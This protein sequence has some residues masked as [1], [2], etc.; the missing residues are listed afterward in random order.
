MEENDYLCRQTISN[1]MTDKYVLY[2]DE[3][4]DLNLS[5]F[6]PQFPIFTLCGIVVSEKQDK[7][8]NEKIDA[9]KLEI[10]NNT[11]IILHSR[12]I[13]KCQNGFEVLF[14]LEVKKKFLESINEIFG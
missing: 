11:N 6:D 4:G 2:L 7:W 3:C 14:D 13:R 1:N 12:D 9:L 10:W 8:L 5:S